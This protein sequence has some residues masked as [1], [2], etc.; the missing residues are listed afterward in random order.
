MKAVFLTVFYIP[1]VM[2]YNLASQ[3]VPVNVRI[4]FSGSYRFV[5]Q[6]A[7]YGPQVGPSFQ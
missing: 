5:P 4:D 3:S 7:L 6:H 1:W 2:F